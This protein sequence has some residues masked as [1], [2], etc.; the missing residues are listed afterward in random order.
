MKQHF[1]GILV[2]ALTV[3]LSSCA[4]PDNLVQSTLSGS[5][6]DSHMEKKEME[7]MTAPD[8]TLQ[9]L[10]GTTV[11]LSDYT[12]ENVYLKYWASWCPICLG[13]LEDLNT[14]SG[15]TLDFKILTIVGPGYKGEKDVEGFREW[16]SG[17]E[18]TENITVLLDE[19]GSYTSAAG[20]RGYPTS[21]WIDK[22]GR[23]LK[24]S[25]GHTDN[26]LI[27]AGFS[28]SD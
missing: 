23:I 18:N 27:K 5:E 17:V 1:G 9:D 20:V 19:N 11:K 22:Q 10:N 16:F 13:G 12:G 2:L 3:L 25:P 26:E 8:F 15:E 7:N 4:A 14:L 6:T 28:G 24:I 21:E